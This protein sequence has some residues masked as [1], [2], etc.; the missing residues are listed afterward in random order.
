MDKASSRLKDEVIGKIE[1]EI[2][3]FAAKKAAAFAARR[4]ATGWIPIVGWVISAVDVVATGYEIATTLPELKEE[5]ADLKKTVENLKTESKKIKD[6]FSKHEEKLKK[7]DTLGDKEKTSIANEVMADSQSAYAAAN[8][9]L[10]ARKCLM[11]S[12]SDSKSVTKTKNGDACCAGQTGHHLMPDAMFRKPGQSSKIPRDKKETAECWGDY[13][14]A[15]SPII[16][17]EGGSANGSHGAVHTA[18]K[19][20]IRLFQNKPTMNYSVA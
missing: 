13:T 16:C 14:E 6:V 20:L 10:R 3:E 18:T 1:A 12:F 19:K 7:F 11:V 17:L 15:A 9:C 4:V 2:T 5:L 8:P